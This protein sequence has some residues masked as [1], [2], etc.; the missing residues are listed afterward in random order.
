MSIP[1]RA[2]SVKNID[3][4]GAEHIEFSLWTGKL[5]PTE[6]SRQKNMSRR[7]DGLSFFVTLA[8]LGSSWSEQRSGTLELLHTYG[9]SYLWRLSPSERRNL[10]L[11]TGPKKPSLAVLPFDQYEWRSRARVFY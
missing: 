1:G 8:D 11:P 5:L 7:S 3:R 6:L 10:A 9:C 4:T 2:Y